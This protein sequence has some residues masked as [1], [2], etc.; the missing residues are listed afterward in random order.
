MFGFFRGPH[1]GLCLR[2]LEWQE[3]SGRGCWWQLE[4]CV[5]PALLS[6]LGSRVL[7]ALARFISLELS[8]IQTVFVT[9]SFHLAAPWRAGRG[10]SRACF[11]WGTF[12]TSGWFLFRNVSRLLHEL[13]CFLG[14]LHTGSFWVFSVTAAPKKY[15]GSLFFFAVCLWCDGFDVPVVY[16]DASRELCCSNQKIFITREQRECQGVLGRP[17]G[18]SWRGEKDVRNWF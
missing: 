7:L 1:A 17:G 8:I 4:L 3:S 14:S 11:K 16:C 6:D 15:P 5:P 2:F 12:K 18:I 13:F 10:E 9:P